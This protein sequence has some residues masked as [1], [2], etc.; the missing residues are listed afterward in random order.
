MLPL[1]SGAYSSRLRATR[2]EMVIAEA[3]GEG[4]NVE[5]VWFRARNFWLCCMKKI[6][7]IGCKMEW[8]N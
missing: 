3:M 4:R 8:M 5:V 2:S 1:V 7:E 6:L